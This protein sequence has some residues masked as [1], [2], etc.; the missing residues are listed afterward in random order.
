MT[1]LSEAVALKVHYPLGRAA[2]S[3]KAVDGVDLRIEAGET[4]ALVGESGCG[5]STLGRALLRLAEATDGVVMFEGCDLATLPAEALRRRRAAM[6]MVF[7]DPFV[8]RH[9]RLT[10]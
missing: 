3:V 9:G 7:Q 4:M 8:D 6:R 5:K 2:G 1:T 10:P